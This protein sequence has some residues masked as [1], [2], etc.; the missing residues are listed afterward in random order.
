MSVIEKGVVV[1][2]ATAQEVADYMVS[3]PEWDFA[4][5]PVKAVAEASVNGAQAA[6]HLTPISAER[7]HAM[8]HFWVSVLSLL[9]DAADNPNVTLGVVGT[10][11][12]ARYG[13]SPDAIHP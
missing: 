4:A 7:G 5:N 6:V 9:V 2:G 12:V 3:A 8:A 10:E 1:A 11:L 13:A